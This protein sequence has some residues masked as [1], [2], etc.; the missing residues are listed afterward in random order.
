[1]SLQ[2]WAGVEG[3]SPSY[4]ATVACASRSGMLPSTRYE[5]TLAALRYL[6]KASSSGSSMRRARPRPLRPRAVL[7]SRG[8]RASIGCRVEEAWRNRR[9]DVWEDAAGQKGAAMPSETRVVGRRRRGALLR[10]LILELGVSSRGVHA[11]NRACRTCKQSTCRQAEPAKYQA[12]RG[13]QSVN[14]CA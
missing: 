10:W 8:Q 1:M 13:T 14:V 7:H 3:S 12:R 2:T 9:L 4:F 5:R 11:C 6:R